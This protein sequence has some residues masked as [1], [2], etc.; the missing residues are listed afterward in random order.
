MSG[1]TRQSEFKVN[2]MVHAAGPIRPRTKYKKHK[3]LRAERNITLPFVPCPGLYLRFSKPRKRALSLVLYLRVR[4]VE[5]SIA[6]SRFECVADE[7]LGSP[8]FSETHEVRGGARIEKHFVD[9]QKTLRMF[10][11]DVITD[12]DGMM[13]LHKREDGRVVDET[14]PIRSYSQ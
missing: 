8:L 11:F 9:L 12:V 7:M 4:A 6:D 10:G 2:I 5:W 1:A 14:E 13:A 3:L